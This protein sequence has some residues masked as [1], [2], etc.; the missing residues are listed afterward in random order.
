LIN[1]DTNGLPNI[2][3]ALTWKIQYEQSLS[4]VGIDP[5]ITFAIVSSF[6]TPLNTIIDPRIMKVVD[7]SEGYTKDYR[8][9][10]K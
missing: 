10:N 7:A 8:T 6:S 9:R 4:C 3:S 1:S 5:Q 2:T